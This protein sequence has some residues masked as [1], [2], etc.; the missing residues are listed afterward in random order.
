MLGEAYD[1]GR[2]VS[3]DVARAAELYQRGAM[4][5]EGIGVPADRALGT[6]LLERGRKAGS[7]LACAELPKRAAAR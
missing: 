7:E 1:H 4:L 3:V 5:L 6:T 2:G